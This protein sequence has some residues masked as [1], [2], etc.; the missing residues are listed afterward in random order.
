MPPLQD[1]PYPT[2][3]ARLSGIASIARRSS[4]MTRSIMRTMN[5]WLLV[6]LVSL[7]LAACSSTRAIPKE[8][9]SQIDRSVS[10]AEVRQAPETYQGR[11]V[12][13]GGQVLSASRLKEGTRLEVLELPLDSKERPSPDR[14]QS[15]GRFYA[16]SREPI[17]P[18]TMVPGMPITI[19]GEITG[20]QV[21][22]L[23]EAD[24]R[25]PTVEIR[26]VH[27]WDP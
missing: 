1:G 24:Y 13:L 12:A 25:Y 27:V 9:D 6:L 23:D 10:F 11:L 14:M 26:H 15:R 8:Y 20:S 22:K 7:T 2:L 5:R 4:R 16:I 18:A 17:D 19:V 3:R 21:G